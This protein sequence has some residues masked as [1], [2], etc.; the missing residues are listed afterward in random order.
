MDSYNAKHFVDVILPMIHI[1][2]SFQRK[3]C[4]NDK[5]CRNFIVSANRQRAPYPFVVAGVN[6]GLNESEEIKDDASKIKYE[7]ADRLRKKYISLDGQNRG[8]ALRRLFLDDLTLSG[9]LIDADDKEVIVNNKYYSNLPLRLQDALKDMKV[10]LCVIEG[11][12]YGELHDIFI[13]INSGDALNPQE[14]RNAINTEISTFVRQQAESTANKDMWPEVYGFNDSKISRSL[15][16]EWVAKAYMATLAKSNWDLNRSD[17]DKFYKSGENKRIQ[18]VPEYSRKN[19]NRFCNI[20]LNVNNFVKYQTEHSAGNFP[21]KMWWLCLYVSELLVDKDIFAKDFESLYQEIHRIDSDLVSQARKDQAM[22]IQM[23]ENKGKPK[24]S[25][26]TKTNYYFQW[27]SN[28]KGST[29]R[30]KRKE[31]F[32]NLFFNSDIYREITQLAA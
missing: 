22:D 12:L 1:D 19:Q 9:T 11:C 26:P 6:S 3:T 8:E 24:D 20:L 31:A 29:D 28:P 16:A 5:T 15:D 18:N 14:I 10:S 17:V 4:W 13:N 2:R 30:V 21:Q 27:A 23:W 25:E 7:D 32:F